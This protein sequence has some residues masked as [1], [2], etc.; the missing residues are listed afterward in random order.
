MILLESIEDRPRH[1]ILIFGAGLI[2][3]AILRS[4]RAARP[5]RLAAVPTR[6]ADPCG[7]GSDLTSAERVVDERRRSG[8][9]PC[10]TVVW[11]AGRA[12]FEAG[13]E[14]TAAELARFSETLAFARK[15]GSGRGDERAHFVMVGSA[16]GLYEGQRLV[17]EASRPDPRRPYG[18][19]K[20]EQQRLLAEHAPALRATV[21]LPSS[22]YGFAHAG[23]RAGLVSTLIV[24]GL[25]QRVTTISGTMSTLR[26]FVWAGDI[27]DFTASEVL[28]PADVGSTRILASARPASIFEIQNMVQETL[29]RRIFLAFSPRATNRDDITFAPSALPRGWSPSDLRTNIQRIYRDALGTLPFAA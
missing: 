12:S 19:L 25:R 5:M 15:I 2:G 1:V 23:Q 21:L 11:S 16:G 27:G 29:G 22:V 20:R 17:T 7:F 18:R 24:N 26:D 13:E 6:W 28:H 3:S 9:S 14:E 8:S 4:L 10:L